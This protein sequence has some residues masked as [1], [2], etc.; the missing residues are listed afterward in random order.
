MGKARGRRS[1]LFAVFGFYP[2]EEA[3]SVPPVSAGNFG[4]SCPVSIFIHEED[5]NYPTHMRPPPSVGGG[6][7][8]DPDLGDWGLGAHIG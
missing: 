8:F 2:L 6:A 7:A 1:A 4:V 5:V 3:V